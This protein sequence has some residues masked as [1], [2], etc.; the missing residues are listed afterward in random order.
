[1][2][3]PAYPHSG[4]LLRLKP[5]N[6]IQENSCG[7]QTPPGQ[8]IWPGGVWNSSGFF[9]LR[10]LSFFFAIHTL[11]HKRDSPMLELYSMGHAAAGGS[12]CPTWCSEVGQALPPVFPT[13]SPFLQ[14]HPDSNSAQILHQQIR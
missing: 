4:L 11:C 14:E 13:C 6:T 12:A 3:H 5:I 10:L 9:L 7:V 2:L 1:V 8:S